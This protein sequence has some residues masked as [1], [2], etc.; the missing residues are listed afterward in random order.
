MLVSFPV[1]VQRD[2]CFVT[3]LDGVYHMEKSVAQEVC[4]CYLISLL[5]TLHILYLFEKTNLE[6]AKEIS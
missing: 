3:L 4:I 1:S 6:L 2:I 5:S